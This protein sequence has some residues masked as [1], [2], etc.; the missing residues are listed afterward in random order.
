MGPVARRS[1]GDPTARILLDRTQSGRG[2]LG[3]DVINRINGRWE[4]TF[5]PDSPLV[6]Y[7]T[8]GV[9]DSAGRQGTAINQIVVHATGATEISAST[10]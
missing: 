8:P 1:S 6:E 10:L 3:Q 2:S 5:D 9:P 4:Q 7:V